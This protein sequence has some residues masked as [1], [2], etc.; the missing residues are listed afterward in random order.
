MILRAQD[1]QTMHVGF[2]D[3][4]QAPPL[5]FVLGDFPQGSLTRNAAASTADAAANSNQKI[6][7]LLKKVETL[8]KEAAEKQAQ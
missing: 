2:P 6:D 3:N 4:S 8:E 5:E 7:A 1:A